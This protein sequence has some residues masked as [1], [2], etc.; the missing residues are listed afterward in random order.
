[1]SIFEKSWFYSLAR[2]QILLDKG[3]SAIVEQMS[4]DPKFEGSNPPFLEFSYK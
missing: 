2:L 1:M 4:H 3:G